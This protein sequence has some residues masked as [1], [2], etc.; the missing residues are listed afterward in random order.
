VTVIAQGLIDTTLRVR[1]DS[2]RTV[3]WAVEAMK[4]GKSGPAADYWQFTG[5]VAAQ[6]PDTA[7]GL[8]K[9]LVRTI[10]STE[11]RKMKVE[12]VIMEQ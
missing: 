10:R 8:K 2:G 7:T 1:I 3:W 6:K 12:T 5:R 9:G 4:S 11:T